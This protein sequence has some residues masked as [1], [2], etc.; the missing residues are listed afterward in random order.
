MTET[1]KKNLLLQFLAINSKPNKDT[2]PELPDLIVWMRFV[3]A[4]AYG[5]W[6]GLSGQKGA[7]GIIFGLN[8]VTFVPIVYCSTF[9]GADAESYGTKLYFS[10]VVNGVSLLMLLWIYFHTLDHAEEEKL[11]SEVLNGTM[12]QAY[13]SDAVDSTGFE[14]VESITEQVPI[15]DSE[16]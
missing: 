12:K 13:L 15:E 6:L 7:A 16:F 1:K 5:S 8:F 9:L 4:I 11:L 10:G 14:G 2:F 3:L